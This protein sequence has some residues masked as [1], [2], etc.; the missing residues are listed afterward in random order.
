MTVCSFMIRILGLAIFISCASL[1]AHDQEGQN[2]I[3]SVQ[4]LI[5]SHNYEQAL[6]LTQ[7]YLQQTPGDFRLW[8]LKGIVLSI[9]G[10]NNDAINAFDKAL[11]LSPN[12]TPALK[13]EVQLLYPAQQKRALPLLEKI[14]EVDP[15]DETA[16]E[17]FANSEK[18]Q[19]N[20]LAADFSLIPGVIGKHPESLEA[21]GYCLVQTKQPQRAV[22]VFEQL[23]ALLPLRTYPKYDLAVVLVDEKQ[24]AAAV[25][26]LEPLLTPDQSDPDILSL[27][28][29]AHEAVGNTPKAVALLRQA[30]IL[31][32]QTASLYNSF[33]AICLNHDS[34][35]VGIDMINA[36][37][38]RIS[39]DP[40]LYISRGLL[41]AQLADYDKAEADFNTAE[42]LDSNQ[43]LSAYAMDLAKLQ[44]DQADKHHSDKELTEIRAQLRSH[45][46]SALLHY[47]LAKLLTNEG[48]DTSS[49]ASS[50]ATRSA[51]LAVKLKPDLVE[52]RNLLASIYL[53]SGKYTLAMEQCKRV[54]EYAPND[55][56]AMYHLIIALRHS[57]GQTAEIHTW[58]KRLAELQQTS[59]QQDT[60]R[61][62]FRLVEQQ[63]TAPQ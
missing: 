14:L 43:S 56:G 60:D 38:E 57:G 35:Q 18:D 51:L 34:F 55:Q 26:I 30:I 19:G 44:R 29:E 4:S 58:V 62:R 32:P 33:A 3:A 24:D 54:L 15:K 40:S 36:G 22:P 63:S 11:G 25:K 41:Y 8:T 12:Y 1:I 50:E 31:S 48:S 42:L 46:D 39:K 20:C 45:P 2:P 6:Q 7:T 37:L 59:L 61:K 27:A 10:S 21:Y 53:R 5:R 9:K 23:A 52:A 47:L 49:A 16:Q 17:M 13:G 28:S